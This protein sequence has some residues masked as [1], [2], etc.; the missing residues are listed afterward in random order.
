MN[1]I[2][3]QYAILFLMALLLIESHN[4]LLGSNEKNPFKRSEIEVKNY[5]KMSMVLSSIIIPLM[6]LVA[7]SFEQFF[8]DGFIALS[9]ALLSSF[10]ILFTLKELLSMMRQKKLSFDLFINQYFI[11]T[12]YLV[13]LTNLSY[14]NWIKE[15]KTFVQ[16]P[17]LSFVIVYSIVL[18]AVCVLL[19]FPK[20]DKKEE[21]GE[22]R[23]TLEKRWKVIIFLDSIIVVFLNFVL[24]KVLLDIFVH[25]IK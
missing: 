18:M 16:T 5:L 13:I 20:T 3:I 17:F 6:I 8:L 10:F 23:V 14:L 25:L 22:K 11:L 24:L 1:N 7:Q 21:E 9:V 4:L 15:I 19:G 12:A 2:V